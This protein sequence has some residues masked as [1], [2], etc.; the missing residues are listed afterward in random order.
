MNNLLN[1]IKNWVSNHLLLSFVIIFIA[2][3]TAGSLVFSG[4]SNGGANNIEQSNKDHS[5]M[6]HAAGT[7]WTCA[8]HP[9]IKMEKPGD[10]PLCGMELVPMDMDDGDDNGDGDYTVKLSN[11]AMK[12]AEVSTTQVE[13]KAPFKEI[14]LP[15][16]V[17]PD[18]RRISELT[19]RF[20]GRIEKLYVNFTGQKVRKGQVLAK[21]YSPELVTAQRELF[22]AFKFQET[23]PG[24]YK[25]ARNK[26]KLWDLSEKQID[27]IVNSGNVKF[28]FDVLS[29]L[30]GTVTMRMVSLGDYVKEGTSLF[31][32]IDLSH[33]WIMFDA[34]ENDIPWIKLKDRIKFKIKSIPNKVFE[35][36]V[37]FIDP[38]LNPKSRV[39]GVRAELNNSKGLLKPEML[40]SGT[41]KTMLPGSGDQLLV[42]KSAVLWSGK[43]SVVYVRT[44]N[45]QNMFRFTEITLGA[46]A[47]DYYVVLE[48]LNDGELVATNGVFKIDAAAQLKGERSMMN[49]SG[50][51]QSLGGMAGMD[52]GGDSKKEKKEVKEGDAKEKPSKKMSMKIDAVFKR[53]FSAAVTSYL[54]LKDAFVA[55]DSEKAVAKAKAMKKTMAKVD[56]ALLKGDNHIMWMDRKKPIDGNLENIISL[57]DVKDQRLAFADVTDAV[58]KTIKMFNVTGLNVHYQF[59]PMARDGKGAYWLSLTSEIKNPYYGDAMLT[60]GETKE[61]LK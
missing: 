58:Y 55:T 60:C 38:V 13:K 51:K 43:K 27:D 32:I 57:S 61:T 46:D 54:A 42:P 40:A 9:Q 36:T 21:I 41:L 34:Y 18:E 6:E 24:Y 2:G 25:A 52:M 14:Y 49:P 15:G 33:V 28:Y 1:N 16:K 37:T 19:S 47:G 59:C 17:M 10:C 4:N 48:G 23:N 3:I 20:S 50:G 8:M 53:Q 39:A 5:E 22:E 44:N 7:L 29:P 31:K 11:S 45:H 12:I 30:T 26:L 56:M 35:S